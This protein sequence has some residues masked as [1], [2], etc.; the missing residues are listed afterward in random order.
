MRLEVSSLCICCKS[1][2]F[3]TVD[4]V[5][6]PFVAKRI[7]G[8][9]PIEI[10]KDWGMRDL[11]CGT[12]YFPCKSVHCQECGTLFLNYRFDSDQ[13]RRLYV[14]YR[15]PTYTAERDF[16]EPGYAVGAARDFTSRHK[17]LDCV[18]KWLSPHL[19]ESPAILDWGGE[20]E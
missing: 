3:L 2:K 8:Y 1:S 19:T 4:V 9:D 12:S 16:Y 10:T 17:Y 7:F 20:M 11:N 18:E 15:N 13:M 6:M 14:G 5:L